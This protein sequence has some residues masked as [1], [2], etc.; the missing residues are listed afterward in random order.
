MWA[1]LCKTGKASFLI[2]IHILKTPRNNS[3]L[4]GQSPPFP[5][6]M[7]RPRLIWPLATLRFFW[8]VWDPLKVTWTSTRC[9]RHWKQAWDQSLPNTWLLSSKQSQKQWYNLFEKSCCLPWEATWPLHWK[10]LS[11]VMSHSLGFSVRNLVV[12]ADNSPLVKQGDSGPLG[13][14]PPMLG[15]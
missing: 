4:P 3:I 8:L 5:A 11:E 14:R 9:L 15:C 13:P 7:N 10:V 2:R 12:E 6:D 1:T